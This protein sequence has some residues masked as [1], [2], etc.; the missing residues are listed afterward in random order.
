M[1]M[2]GR[3]V[4]WYVDPLGAICIGLFTLCSWASLAFRQ[5]WLLVGK[6]APADFI[7]KVI[8]L[9]VTH[10]EQ[11]MKVDAVSTPSAAVRIYDNYQCF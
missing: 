11:I 1:S 4:E 7:S 2:I 5:I 10:D 9:T 8:Y 6:T 3:R